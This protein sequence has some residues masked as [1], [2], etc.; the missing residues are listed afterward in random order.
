MTLFPAGNLETDNPQVWR[1][2]FN[3]QTWM[4]YALQGAISLMLSEFNWTQEGDVDPLTASQMA[5]DVLTNLVPAV[6]MIGTIQMFAGAAGS[7]PNGTL[8]CDGQSYLRADFPDLF[9]VIGTTWGSVDGSHFNVPDMRGRAP[10]GVGTGSGL[11][12]RALATEVGE[13]DHTLTIAEMPS[14]SHAINNFTETG[15]A[16]PPP[17]DAGTEIPHITSF[18]ASEGGGGSHNTMQ[19]S[20]AVN[21]F[22]VAIHG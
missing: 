9:A 10:I 4:L 11:T 17:S 7:I 6:D 14:H 3:E 21:F 22:I 2:T 8:I 16:V 1:T 15:T 18:T 19:P 20:V 12:P 13:E 5:F